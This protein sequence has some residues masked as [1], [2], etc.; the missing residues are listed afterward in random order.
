MAVNTT[1]YVWRWKS[2]VEDY[3]N[4]VKF[5]TACSN[6]I[7]ALGYAVRECCIPYY[8]DRQDQYSTR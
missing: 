7:S 3:Q 2:R 8:V 6:R 5:I 1:A 4:G